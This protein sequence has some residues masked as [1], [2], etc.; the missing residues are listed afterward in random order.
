MHRVSDDSNSLS[1]ASHITDAKALCSKRQT[2][3]ASK[4]VIKT[5]NKRKMSE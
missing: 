2:R 4:E 3:T 1:T 5:K